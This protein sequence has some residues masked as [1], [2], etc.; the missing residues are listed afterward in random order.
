MGALIL[1]LVACWWPSSAPVPSQPYAVEVSLGDTANARMA[2]E[3]GHPR[4]EAAPPVASAGSEPG[5]GQ[6]EAKAN[7]GVGG[8][9]V[10]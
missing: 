1:L 2:P 7:P 10:D 8:D 4:P 9:H 6:P 5:P 3:T